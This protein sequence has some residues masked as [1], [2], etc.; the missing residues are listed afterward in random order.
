[1]DERTRAS[2]SRGPIRCIR[3]WLSGTGRKADLTLVA[4]SA[5]EAPSLIVAEHRHIPVIQQMLSAASR[6]AAELGYRQWWDP[7]PVASIR[8]GVDLGETYLLT[9]GQEAVG[10]ITVSWEDELFWGRCPPDAGYV[11]RLCVDSVVAHKGL[12]VELLSWASSQ[13]ADRG[14]RWIRLDTPS[15]NDRLRMYYEALGFDH[16][17]DVDITMRGPDARDELWRAALYERQSGVLTRSPR[18]A[19]PAGCNL[20][21]HDD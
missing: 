18:P 5:R 1:M 4:R 2:R 8:D 17:G 10:T 11:H 15:S 9:D 21:L 12:G 3:H 13:I 16:R 19:P 6:R 7:F 20:G 14:R